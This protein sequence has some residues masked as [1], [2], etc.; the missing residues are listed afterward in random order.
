MS[1]PSSA[2]RIVILTAG[3]GGMYC[4]SCLHDNM[5]ATS[6]TKLGVDVQ[7]I[8]TYT[9]I[10][11]DEPNVSGDK[12]LMGGINV[13][14]QQVLP[15]FRYTPRFLDRLWD[16]PKLLNWAAERGVKTTAAD[17]GPLTVSML[18]GERGNQRKE[19]ARL[20]KWLAQVE[21]SLVNLS[22]ILIAGCVRQLK[23][24]LRIPILVTLQGD[25]IFL[26]GLLPKFRTQA[27]QEIKRIAEEVDGFITHSHFYADHMADLLSLDRRRIHVV[28]LG[29]TLR[30][31]NVDDTHCL[32][33][34]PPTIGYLARL[35]PEKGLHLVC[36]ALAILRS[37][38]ETANVQLRIAGWLGAQHQRY[39]DECFAT[40]RSRLSDPG[41]H[42]ALSGVPKEGSRS[43]AE[44]AEEAF[45]YQGE[46]DRDGK[47]EFLRS[48][49]VLSVPS[50]YEE[51]KGLYVL[52]AFAE[53][54]PVVEPRHGAF[55]EI[56]ET[57]GGGR[58]FV[59]NDVGDLTRVLGELL[60][61]DKLRR[62]LGDSA[63][64]NV[65]RLHSAEAMARRVVEVMES[66]VGRRLR[67]D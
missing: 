12:V 56:V 67:I 22:N 21:P 23:Q 10:R 25:D 52:E 29:V 5:L 20:C 33:D 48:V 24:E 30:P 31:P 39:V 49:D 36:E 11:T 15:L 43:Q 7:L 55:P 14:L 17:L 65:R 9:P 59:P 1:L 41:R 34:R 61:D 18:R 54:V 2:P 57:T 50:P 27:I 46:V 26:N 8:P 13:Y 3:A 37:R 38:P 47:R 6:L 35:A 66:F 4:G 64:Q 32:P 53:G 28:P 60:T 62:S 45:V 51:P 44:S 16:H 42:S 19:V 63:Q 40:L 58:L